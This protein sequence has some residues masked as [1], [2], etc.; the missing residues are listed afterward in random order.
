VF[1]PYRREATRAR[2]CA[3]PASPRSVRRCE[4]QAVFVRLSSRPPRAR[5]R[6]PPAVPNST[7][8][9]RSTLGVSFRL[10]R[11]RRK[12]A[13]R[14]SSGISGGRDPR[15]CP[16]EG[17]CGWDARR[18][19]GAGTSSR[20]RETVRATTSAPPRTSGCELHVV[21]PA[22]PLPVLSHERRPQDGWCAVG[23]ND[24]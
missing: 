7:R 10:H 9:R 21:D 17:A 23:A 5:C 8:R 22:R 19:I 24:S 12:T 14:R 20:L 13:G 18:G 2:W 16:R 4:S 1:G 3:P 6:Y 11:G 15:N